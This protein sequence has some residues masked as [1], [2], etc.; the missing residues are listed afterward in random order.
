[1]F[2]NKQ[3]NEWSFVYVSEKKKFYYKFMLLLVLLWRL[4]RFL[5]GCVEL[6]FFSL[7]RHSKHKFKCFQGAEIFWYHFTKKEIKNDMLYWRSRVCAQLFFFT[8]LMFF[9]KK[10]KKHCENLCLLIFFSS[11]FFSTLIYKG[12]HWS[13]EIIVPSK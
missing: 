7:W 5:Y 4:R 11:S 10:K 6:F 12:T 1:M 13:I 9:R 2:K 8:T 3:K